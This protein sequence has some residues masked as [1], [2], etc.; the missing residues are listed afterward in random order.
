MCSLANKLR[1]LREQMGMTKKDV[2]EAVGVHPSS[3]GNL[4]KGSI[5]QA[6]LLYALA[7]LFNVSMEYLINPDQEEDKIEF[8]QFPALSSNDMTL[9]N[10]FDQLDERDQNEVLEIINLKILSAKRY[11]S[12]TNLSHSTGQTTESKMA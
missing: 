3:I 5:P 1:Y 6:D 12:K 7:K 4:E 10:L 9:L 2:A 11:R 8:T